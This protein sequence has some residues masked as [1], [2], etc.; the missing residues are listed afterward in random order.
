MT[1]G[2]VDASPKAY[3]AET[4]RSLMI[5]IAIIAVFCLVVT[6]LMLANHDKIIRTDPR[7]AAS[8]I[9]IK[10][11]LHKKPTDEALKAK[12]RNTDAALRKEYLRRLDFANT[13]SYLLLIGIAGLLITIPAAAQYRR[14]IELPEPQTDISEEQRHAARLSKIGIATLGVVITGGMVTIAMNSGGDLTEGYKKAVSDYLKSKP[15]SPS[16]QGQPAPMA[17]AASTPVGAPPAQN[18]TTPPAMTGPIPAL[19]PLPGQANPT[20]ASPEAAK[21]APATPVKPPQLAVE[22]AF[23]A[24]DYAPTLEDYN[25][26]WP[27]FRGPSA[28]MASGPYPTSWDAASGKSV[29]WKTPIPLPGWNSPVVWKDRVFL[30]GADKQKRELYCF[31]AQDGKL[32]WSKTIDVLVAGKPLEVYDDTGY[33]APSMAVN[34]KHVFAIF[35]N[36]DVV[37]YSLTG[38]MV[39]QRNLGELESMYGY[40]S[41]LSLYKSLLIVQYDQGSGDDGKSALIALQSSTGKIVWLTHRDVA[42]SW[43][44]PLVVN[45]GESGLIITNANPWSIG[46]DALTGKELWRAKLMSGDVA[47]SAAYA[48]GIAYLCNS[49]AV[50]AAVRTDGTGDVTKSKL[51]WQSTDGLPDITSPASNGEYLFTV[52]TE[53]TLTCHDTKQGKKLWDH[54]YDGVFK[55]SPV[56]IGN[57]VYLLDGDGVMHIVS[58]KQSFTEESTASIGEKANATPAFAAGRLYIRGQNH[59]FCIGAR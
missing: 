14:K 10:Q 36:G 38:E 5:T 51:L 7:Y 18:T 8:L 12:L 44:S 37:C 54:T 32:L 45:S 13:G 33:A 4:Y 1:N 15:A 31:A 41:S 46:Y 20:V 29:L 11:R 25:Q 43:S 9:S 24:N 28:G 26:N 23:D 35:P 2:S 57:S 49:G 52:T 56:I 22:A 34:G 6:T 50:L 53:G 30:A 42:N 59:L 16:N 21:Q 55:A 58:L 40:A 17:S 19:P 3:A 48:D 27:V 39:W 47:P